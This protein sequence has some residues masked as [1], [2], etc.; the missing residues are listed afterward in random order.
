MFTRYSI[1]LKDP[2]PYVD[3]FCK[4]SN[5]RCNTLSSFIHIIY[6][7]NVQLACM[8]MKGSSSVFDFDG[9]FWETFRWAF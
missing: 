1:A 7:A 9:N 5:E 3:T 8:V 4:R 2:A 6:Q